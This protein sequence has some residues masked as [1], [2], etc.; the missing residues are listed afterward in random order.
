MINKNIIIAGIAAIGLYLFSQQKK[1]I[2]KTPDIVPIKKIAKKIPEASTP[3]AR[4]KIAEKK[5]AA[6]AA[7]AAEKAAEKAAFTPEIKLAIATLSV[8]EKIQALVAYRKKIAAEKKVAPQSISLTP[9]QKARVLLEAAIKKASNTKVVPILLDNFKKKKKETTEISFNFDPW[10]VWEEPKADSTLFDYS[11]PKKEKDLSELHS[12][13][14][15]FS[16]KRSM[17]KPKVAAQKV[18]ISR[19]PVAQIRYM[20]SHA[21]ARKKTGKEVAALKAEEVRRVAAWKANIHKI[22]VK[23]LRYMISHAAAQKKTGK[24]VAALKAEEVRRVAAWKAVTQKR[25]IAKIRSAVRRPMSK[26]KR[27]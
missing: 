2:H 22:P 24:E 20:I 19:L 1:T 3:A 14:T 8:A 4:R 9:D 27:R 21:A 26:L 17:S 11:K 10:P 12:A 23:K 16:K 7:A 13:I 15:W 18:D 6:A 25:R 5:A